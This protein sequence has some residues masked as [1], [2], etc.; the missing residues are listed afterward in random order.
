MLLS[1][2][3]HPRRI[4]GEVHNLPRPLLARLVI[5]L[6]LFSEKLFVRGSQLRPI[7]LYRQFRELAGELERHL[8]VIIIHRCVGVGAVEFAIP[9]TLL[10]SLPSPYFTLTVTFWR[11]LPIPLTGPRFPSPFQ[12]PS[13]LCR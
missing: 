11:W 10:K 7:D 6:A 5:P 1:S 3:I 4:A 2:T 12:S 8:V 13:C 9:T